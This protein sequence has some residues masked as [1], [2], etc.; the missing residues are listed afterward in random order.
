M[1]VC[2]F[3]ARLLVSCL[4]IRFCFIGFLVCL[5][6]CLFVSSLV[7]CCFVCL[8]VC[9]LVTSPHET[10]LS[11][12]ACGQCSHDNLQLLHC[13]DAVLIQDMFWLNL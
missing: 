5:F 2:F 10:V 11:H 6:D 12:F 4:L 3:V 9:V 13:V 7:S 1:L 8:L